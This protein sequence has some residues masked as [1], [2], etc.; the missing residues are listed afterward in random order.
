MHETLY[1][2][3][4][5]QSICP[6]LSVQMFLF[7]VYGLVSF[8]I[9]IWDDITVNDKTYCSSKHKQLTSAWER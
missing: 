8:L 9:T 7:L 2:M 4:P 6:C 3:C 1:N 5:K